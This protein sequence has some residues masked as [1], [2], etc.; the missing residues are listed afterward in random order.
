MLTFC[1]VDAFFTIPS[2]VYLFIPFATFGQF[3]HGLIVWTKLAAIDT[4][5][6]SLRSL[7]DQLD[8]KSIL[9]ELAARF[10]EPQRAAPGGTLV[11]NDSFNYW[12]KRLRWM[13]HAYETRPETV[14]PEAER[15]TEKNARPANGTIQPAP[16]DMFSMDFFGLDDNFWNWSGDF[17]LGEC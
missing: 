1:A 17:D 11:N 12:S 9:D 3:A 14:F 7:G 6:W 13:W 8:F 15:E 10:E 5:E 2:S 4:E 16:E